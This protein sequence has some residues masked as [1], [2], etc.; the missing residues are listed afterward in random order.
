[1]T[2]ATEYRIDHP[3]QE[4]WLGVGRSLPSGYQK[5]LLTE[6][7]ANSKQDPLVIIEMSKI[8]IMQSDVTRQMH[9]RSTF[10]VLSG[11]NRGRAREYVDTAGNPDEIG[12][13]IRWF[14]KA[15]QSHIKHP[16]YRP[17]KDLAKLGLEL[18][19]VRQVGDWD[20]TKE[21]DEMIRTI[22]DRAQSER[23]LDVSVRERPRQRAVAYRYEPMPGDIFS[24]SKFGR[25]RRRRAVADVHVEGAVDLHIF[26]ES[27][28]MAVLGELDA[29]DRSRILSDVKN[30]G[31][32]N[33]FTKAGR[34]NTIA[35]QIAGEYFHQ[36]IDTRGG[37]RNIVPISAHYVMVACLD[38]QSKGLAA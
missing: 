23:G 28:G 29:D 14:S 18:G 19:G 26:K 21:L 30:S 8:A 5:E 33:S 13:Y 7:F 27:L 31:A 4:D 6:R 34:N 37:D 12:G 1:M 11:A 3:V 2:Q 17:N 16:N 9:E 10:G 22:P 36:A 38:P 35:A 32:Q 15:V 25:V 24:E 20:N